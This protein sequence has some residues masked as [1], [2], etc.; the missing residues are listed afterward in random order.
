RNGVRARNT[1]FVRLISLDLPPRFG[2][3][4]TKLYDRHYIFWFLPAGCGKKGQAAYSA[5]LVCAD[6]TICCGG[7]G[8]C[9]EI[10]A[11]F[12]RMAAVPRGA[13]QDHPRQR[14]AV[15]EPARRG[16]FMPAIVTSRRAR[17]MLQH[18]RR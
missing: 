10:T 7:K 4:H 5:S 1:S 18:V 11:D 13:A 16:P 14:S 3:P 8:V 12:R 6:S 2:L 17:K 15:H 9:P